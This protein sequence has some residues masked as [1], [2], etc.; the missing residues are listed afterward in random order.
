[1]TMNKEE[2]KRMKDSVD[3]LVRKSFESAKDSEMGHISSSEFLNQ[4]EMLQKL[5]KDFSSANDFEL[6]AQRVS[7]MESYFTDLISRVDGIIV[8]IDMINQR[9]KQEKYDQIKK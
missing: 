4:D 7:K 5:K 2:L 8:N 6:L 3:K 9:K 1:M